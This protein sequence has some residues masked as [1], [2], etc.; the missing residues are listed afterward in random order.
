MPASLPSNILLSPKQLVN[1]PSN[2]FCPFLWEVM[3]LL[4]EV[5][6]GPCWAVLGRGEAL[7]KH[8]D[9]CLL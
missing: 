9:I 8:F 5:L 6:S 7:L 1:F 2:P 3:V 4:V